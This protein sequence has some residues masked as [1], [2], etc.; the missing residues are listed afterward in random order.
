MADAGKLKVRC[1]IDKSLYDRAYKSLNMNAYHIPYNDG[2]LLYMYISM[3]DDEVCRARAGVRFQSIKH[4]EKLSHCWQFR[5][6][7]ACTYFC[8]CVCV[9]FGLAY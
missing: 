9:C 8:V 4:P 3:C 2:W 6:H 7:A 1:P 5:A